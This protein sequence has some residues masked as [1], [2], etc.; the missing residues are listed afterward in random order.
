MSRLLALPV[1]LF[2]YTA[3]FVSFVYL[4]GFV[5]GIDALPT[6][7]DKGL[8]ASP[9]VA[10]AIDLG[11]IA[12]FGVQHS[13]MA[14]PAF[15][16]A[17]TRVIPAAME[18]SVYCLATALCLLLIF[19]FWHPIAGTVWSVQN[20][21]ARM[22]LWGVFLLGWAILFISTWLIS[23]FELFGLSQAWHH[24]RGQPVPEHTFKTPLF[25]KWVRHPIYTGFLLGFWATPDMSLGHLLFAIGTTVYIFI[26]IAHEERDLVAHFGEEY[27]RYRARV[28]SVFPG[29]GRR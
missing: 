3:F 8:S 2:C 11:L 19:V 27:A 22:A 4:V 18:R 7:V 21:V 13:V 12:L 29:V 26:G 23:H 5:A 14:R 28:G 9:I 24:F 15:K 20:E 1:A 10:A 6:H 16:S 17:W 25:Y